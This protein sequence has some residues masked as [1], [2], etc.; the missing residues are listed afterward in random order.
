LWDGYRCAIVDG[1]LAIHDR[2]RAVIKHLLEDENTD[3]GNAARTM[4]IEGIQDR[5]LEIIQPPNRRY[6]TCPEE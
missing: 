6:D 5:V 1:W 3:P 2:R 4:T